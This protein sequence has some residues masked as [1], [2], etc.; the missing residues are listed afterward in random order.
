MKPMLA[1]L[2]C[3]T[4]AAAA[5]P[6]KLTVTKTLDIGAAPKAVWQTI[7]GFCG[8]GDW[9]P[10]IERCVLTSV[11]RSP[12]RQLSLRG[13]GTIVEKQ[14]GRDAARMRYTYTILSG[15]LPVAHY[16]S[17]L[18]VARKGAGSTVTWTGTFEAAGAPDEAARAAIE[19]VYSSGLQGLA[20][21]VG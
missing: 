10:A 3:V 7:G 1:I 14:V 16:V 20:D 6:A 18:S 17:T 12:Q 21:K 11:K 8:I 15:P 5:P 19:G 4:L 13:G 9:H 2:A